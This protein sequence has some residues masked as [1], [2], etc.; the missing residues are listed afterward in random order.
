MSKFIL[1][2]LFPVAVLGQPKTNDLSAPATA[3]L[4]SLDVKQLEKAH[5]QMTDSS[6]FNW[7]FVPPTQAKRDGL[8]LVEMTP[9]QQEKCMA[10]LRTFL[11]EQGY[12][13]ATRIMSL[14]EVL[15]VLEP[16]NPSR[17]PGNYFVS[18][19]GDPATDKVWAWKFSGHH[20]A[21][22]YTIVNGRMAF[23]P[24]FFGS[25]PDIVK[26]GPRKGEQVLK[27]EEDLGFKLVNGMDAD[28]LNK[29][30]I[31]MVAFNDIQTSNAPHAPALKDEGIDG[32]A[33]HPDQLLILKQ[34]I[35]TYL[36]SM[37]PWLAEARMKRIMD[38]DL[39]KVRFAWAGGRV[40]GEGHYYRVQGKS[41]LI[42][43]DNTQTNANHIHSVWR[44]MKDGDYGIDL[45]KEHYREAHKN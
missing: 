20:L 45:I 15:K 23:A 26:E 40:A 9:A 6:R 16:D 11:S 12:S 25:N 34:L 36:S 13:K 21:L 32:N 17:I 44:D 31:A 30:M 33:L 4:K 43:F 41:F 27:D 7:H 14:E 42:E 2:F 38:E 1:F 39:R 18:I 10:L 3:F 35:Q 24:F 37:V 29:T 8:P 28:Q 22:N 5:F 19:Y